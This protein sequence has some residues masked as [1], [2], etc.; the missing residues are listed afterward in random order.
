ME[1]FIEGPDM[2]ADGIGVVE[3]F[4]IFCFKLVKSAFTRRKEGENFFS[5]MV[6][7]FP[8]LVVSIEDLI[9][10]KRDFF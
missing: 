8:R 10:L 4:S 3:E 9:G 2:D 6:E 7:V 1:P 5:M